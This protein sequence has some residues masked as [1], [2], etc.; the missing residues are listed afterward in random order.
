MN[1][2]NS[3]LLNS[4]YQA[5]TTHIMP[6]TSIIPYLYCKWCTTKVSFLQMPILLI[7]CTYFPFQIDDSEG[8]G[9]GDENSSRLN[10]FVN[11]LLIQLTYDFIQFIQDNLLRCGKVG[12]RM[13]IQVLSIFL[14]P[15][16]IC[17][18]D[19]IK[20]NEAQHMSG[21]TKIIEWKV[22]V[23]S[24]GEA[25]THAHHTSFFYH[26]SIKNKFALSS[27]EFRCNAHVPSQMLPYHFLFI[28]R[29]KWNFLVHSSDTT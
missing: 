9:G 23:V 1:R 25:R 16:R 3:T 14:H 21:K 5:Y 22:L 19:W 18:G 20:M 4:M 15:F 2:L 8:G 12:K 7:P 17:I 29:W 11:L 24:E 27:I 26:L 28:R 13:K 10:R 6:S